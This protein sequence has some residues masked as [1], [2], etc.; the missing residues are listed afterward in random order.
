MKIST[1]SKIIIRIIT[2]F[3]IAIIMSF[4]AEYFREFLGDW[5]CLGT[6]SPQNPCLYFAGDAHGAQWHWGYRH[7]LFFIMGFLIFITQVIS[8]I[9]LTDKEA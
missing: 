9:T 4:V 2:F 6:R 8:V 3:T 5:E 1:S 7:W